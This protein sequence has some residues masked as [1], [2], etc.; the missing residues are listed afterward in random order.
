M[1]YHRDRKSPQKTNDNPVTTAGLTLS[2]Y[3]PLCS[4]NALESPGAPTD[5]SRIPQKRTLRHLWPLFATE[6]GDT[7]TECDRLEY[8]SGPR[9]APFDFRPLERITRAGHVPHVGHRSNDSGGKSAHH[10]YGQCNDVI[11]ATVIQS[12]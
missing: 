9:A 6:E 5:A 10:R 2:L 11:A 4:G 3:D 8:S 12:S 1:F 7:A